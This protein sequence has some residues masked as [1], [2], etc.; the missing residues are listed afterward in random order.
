MTNRQ[1]SLSSRCH[2]RCRRYNCDDHR[3]GVSASC[4]NDDEAPMNNHWCTNISKYLCLCLYLCLPIPMPIP[5]PV[6]IPIP[7]KYVS[8]A[9]ESPQ[10]KRPPRSGVRSTWPC[11]CLRSW[12]SEQRLGVILAVCLSM[13]FP[14]PSL[15][16]ANHGATQRSSRGSSGSMRGKESLSPCA[17]TYTSVFGSPLLCTQPLNVVRRVCCLCDW[18]SP[19]GVDERRLSRVGDGG[20]VRPSPACVAFSEAKSRAAKAMQMILRIRS[21]RPLATLFQDV[22]RMNSWLWEHVV[23]CQHSPA[24]P[25]NAAV[26]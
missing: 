11:S 3:F 17:N 12:R 22:D 15:S 19:I 23:L 1:A 20:G 8:S 9:R 26:L 13:Q 4:N 16:Q 14:P 5:I 24:Q 25:W 10:A 18:R 21:L 2:S 7:N 6:P